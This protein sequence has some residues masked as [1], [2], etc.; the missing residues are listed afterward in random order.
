MEVMALLYL[1]ETSVGAEKWYPAMKIGGSTCRAQV[2]I[3]RSATEPR[4][5][6]GEGLRVKIFKEKEEDHTHVYIGL[7]GRVRT[8]N[9]G[10][11][12]NKVATMALSKRQ[13]MTFTGQNSRRTV[14]P[15]WF[16]LNFRGRPLVGWEDSTERGGNK[17]GESGRSQWGRE[18][19]I[20]P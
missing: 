20:F 13:A 19:L 12:G 6:I 15:P 14:R 2:L 17:E 7:K 9:L 1:R 3:G 16:R 8:R 10:G 18:G 11:L 4:N 5:V